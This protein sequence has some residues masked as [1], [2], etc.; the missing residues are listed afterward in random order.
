VRRV[1]GERLELFRV[2][3]TIFRRLREIVYIYVVYIYAMTL[4]YMSYINMST[5]AIR[6]KYACGD[7]FF[8]RCVFHSFDS[9]S[10]L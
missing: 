8:F 7:V 3:K 1:L 9:A 10:S 2:R 4:R 5:T 6:A